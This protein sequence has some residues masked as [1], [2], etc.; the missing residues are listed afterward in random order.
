MLFC[1]SLLSG[2]APSQFWPWSS[3]FLFP[4]KSPS[5]KNCSYDFLSMPSNFSPVFFASSSTQ[6]GCLGLYFPR[7]P[8]P[9]KAARWQPFSR[10]DEIRQAQWFCFPPQMVAT[11]PPSL[12]CMWDPTR[13]RD[14]KILRPVESSLKSRASQSSITYINTYNTYIE[15]VT[16]SRAHALLP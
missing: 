5:P 15:E 11:L 9:S 10:L 6:W 2:W 1:P 8:S 14:P 13:K 7:T 12:P 3:C 16:R 4:P